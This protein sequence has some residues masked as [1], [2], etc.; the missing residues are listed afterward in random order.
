MVSFRRN[1]SK[2]DMGE[3]R[4]GVEGRAAEREPEKIRVTDRRR[5]H[6]DDEGASS[7]ASEGEATAEEPRLKPTYVEELEARTRAAE[8]Q[9]RDV[10]ARFEKVRDDLRRETDEVRQRLNRSADERAQREKA[11]F[12]TSLLPALDN[13]RRA[14]DAAES[15]GSQESLM[16]G[17]RG[18]IQGFENALAQAGVESVEA[19]GQP[20]D[21][22]MHEA[23]DTKEVEPEREGI[24]TAEY[25]AGYRMGKQ[26]LRP[27]RVQVGRAREEAQAATE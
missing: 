14:V 24:I 22:E 16:D 7:S 25:S 6:I 10:Q 8:Q 1:K 19:L 26:L 20:F 12:V 15:G 2:T 4:E 9:A 17:L 23:V 5:V 21:P 11:S 3:N 13:L 18:T 27:A